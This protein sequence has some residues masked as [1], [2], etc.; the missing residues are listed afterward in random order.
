M[1]KAQE[2][3]EKKAKGEGLAFA[4]AYTPDDVVARFHRLRRVD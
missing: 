4:P 1:E 3:A 2:G